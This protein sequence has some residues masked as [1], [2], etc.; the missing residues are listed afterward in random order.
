VALVHS[1]SHS[2]FDLRE[3]DR[4]IVRRSPHT[5]TLLHPSNHSYYRML[6]EKLGWSGLPRNPA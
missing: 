5:V 3:N 1:D 4:V 6:R 2:H